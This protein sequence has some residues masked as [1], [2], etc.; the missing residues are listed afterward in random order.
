MHQYNGSE[1]GWPFLNMTF[2]R[3]LIIVPLK[4]YSNLG[5]Q[6]GILFAIGQKIV[7]GCLLFPV[8]WTI[9]KLNPYNTNS[10][11]CLYTTKLVQNKSQPYR[12]SQQNRLLLTS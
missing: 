9:A 3:L 1:I 8:L 5:E 6:T 2:C 4:M 12:I 7:K 11:P 10:I